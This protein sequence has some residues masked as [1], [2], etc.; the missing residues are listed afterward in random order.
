M[1]GDVIGFDGN[2]VFVR[3]DADTLAVYNVKLV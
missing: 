3:T 1:Q 2:F